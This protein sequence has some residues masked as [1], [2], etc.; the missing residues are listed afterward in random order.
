MPLTLPNAAL[1]VFSDSSF[2]RTDPNH[3]REWIQIVSSDWDLMQEI[4]K[5]S[6]RQRAAAP[7]E[8]ELFD[9]LNLRLTLERAASL[10]T[11]LGRSHA[12]QVRYWAGWCLAAGWEPK[13]DYI[14]EAIEDV[15]IWH[16]IFEI[17][18]LHPARLRDFGFSVAKE[19]RAVSEGTWSYD[20]PQKYFMPEC[21][22]LDAIDDEGST[23]RIWYNEYGCYHIRLLT[24]ASNNCKA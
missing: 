22:Q 2:D 3:L 9:S 11:P 17:E 5:G 24:P 4:N 7:A 15:I 13:D 1:P 16:A 8:L 18:V 19:R 20:D 21:D 23:W 14:P 12:M 6:H 10:T